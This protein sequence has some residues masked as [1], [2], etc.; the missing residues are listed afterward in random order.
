MALF[1]IQPLS[2]PGVI[3]WIMP[4][5]VSPENRPNFT[6]L[7]QADLAASVFRSQPP[8]GLLNCID[9]KEPYL[10]QE[11]ILT[12]PC[13]E[14]RSVFRYDITGAETRNTVM[15][16]L[17]RSCA[18][19]VGSELLIETWLPTLAGEFHFKDYWSLAAD[20]ERLIMAHRD[21]GLAGQTVVHR[22]V[23]ASAPQ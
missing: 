14:H 4:A 20:G 16:M 6:G 10:I 5:P 11:M 12:Q 8:E 23:P 9:H 1:T 13:G 15:G 3:V 17:A 19:W 22:R 2:L 18:S 21:D 7:W